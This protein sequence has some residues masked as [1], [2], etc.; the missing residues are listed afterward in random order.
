MCPWDYEVDNDVRYSSLSETGHNGSFYIC[1]F[2]PP[3]MGCLPASSA[4]RDCLVTTPQL[5]REWGFP[6]H[7]ALELLQLF[8]KFVLPNTNSIAGLP[9]GCFS[10]YC[11]QLLCNSPGRRGVAG[12]D[13][14]D[15]HPNEGLCSC[16]CSG[17]SS[18]CSSPGIWSL[19]VPSSL[20]SGNSSSPGNLC[21]P[22]Q[23]LVITWKRG[24]GGGEQLR[25]ADALS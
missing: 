14:A 21:T 3:D 20:I 2:F 1:S 25:D 7:L 6:A 24:T 15:P 18:S 22:S 12:G 8:S 11:K 9:C 23:L 13:R 17:E 10:I 16:T 4:E 5:E 19:Q